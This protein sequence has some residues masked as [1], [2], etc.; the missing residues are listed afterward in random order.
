MDLYIL[1]CFRC[2][3]PS[4]IS[5]RLVDY[6]GFL[7]LCAN[8][9]VSCLDCANIVNPRGPIIQI[10]CSNPSCFQQAF[11]AFVLERVLRA[12]GH[13]TLRSWQLQNG[14]VLLRQ[15]RDMLL[16]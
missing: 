1:R 6:R 14:P 15:E 5:S 11:Q 16:T 4:Q 9:H 7:Y 12:V 8:D 13:M 10:P 3:N 2:R